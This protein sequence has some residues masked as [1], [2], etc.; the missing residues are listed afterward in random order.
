[1][2][3]KISSDY[4]TDISSRKSAAQLRKH[5]VSEV[6]LHGSIVLDF[7]DVRTVSSSFADE[8]FAILVLE[9][10]EAWFKNSVKVIN[11][12]KPVKLSIIASVRDRLSPEAS[13]EHSQ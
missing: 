8:A 12:S 1:M 4:G 5:T 7:A 2:T 9:R 6:D 13:S 10:G 11:L 3:I